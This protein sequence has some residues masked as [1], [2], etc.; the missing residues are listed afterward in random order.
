MAKVSIFGSLTNVQMLIH[1]LF[2]GKRVGTDAYDNVYYRAAPRRGTKRERR[3]VIYRKGFDAST[4]PPE[5]HGWLHHQ[6]DAVPSNDSKHRKPWQ[7]P[8]LA[9]MTG[10]DAAYAPPGLHGPRDHATG[11]YKAWAPPQ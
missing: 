2:K 4:V 8:P 6:T 5:W 11:D 3:W 1:T 7:K 10:T 9:N